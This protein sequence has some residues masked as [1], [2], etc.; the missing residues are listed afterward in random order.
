MYNKVKFFFSLAVPA[1]PSV[2]SNASPV[3]G[4]GGLGSGGKFGGYA[5]AAS[6]IAVQAQALPQPPSHIPP[7]AVV[8]PQL[9]AA[10]PPVAMPVTASHDIPSLM[11]TQGHMMSS[12]PQDNL[13]FPM[14]NP[15]NSLPIPMETG[16]EVTSIA[17][18]E[19]LNIKGRDARH[20]IMQKLMRK[21][22]TR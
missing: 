1:P 13:G 19:N 22:E 10:V 9:G 6:V 18:Q 12:Q 11:A 7:P 5:D 3:G 14:A 20:M 15:N 8:I 2:P 21:N 17:A 4:A 16:Q